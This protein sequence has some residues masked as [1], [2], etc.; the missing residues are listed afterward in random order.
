MHNL[1]AIKY[2]IS[3]P[4]VS[5]TG[6][7]RTML[8]Y[9]ASHF[10][11]K[12]PLVV[13]MLDR[14]PDIVII[15]DEQRQV[16]FANQALLDFVG[17]QQ[18]QVVNGQ[19]PGDLLGCDHA[20][21]GCGSTR[22][23]RTCGASRAILASLKGE[24]S[25]EECRIIRED[26]RSLDLRV[27][28][29]P[30]S[31]EDTRFT[32]FTVRDISHEKRRQILEHAFFHDILNTAGTLKGFADIVSDATPDELDYIMAHVQRTAG[33]LIDEINAQKELVAAEND[34]LKPNMMSVQSWEL[35]EG[36][37]EQYSYHQTAAHRSILMAEKAQDLT[38][39]TDPT[40]LSR[41]LSN[42]IKNALEASQPGQTV[43]LDCW[44]ED[45]QIAFSIHNPMTMSRDV[46]LQLFQRSFSTKGPGRGIGTYSVR[47]LTE[48]YLQ[49]RVT[50]STSE[51]MGTTFIVHYP[52]HTP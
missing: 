35:L 38:F 2:A 16:M 33:R 47:L 13:D 19:R 14:I 10:F 17:T 52:L 30:F 6:G 41:V 4:D 50:F 39:T 37:R 3:R 45:D 49:G 22:F 32:V 25:V 23:C 18:R 42:L 7:I 43:T 21:Q 15:L 40:L 27:W 12:N 48:R 1:D 28:A 9:D 24:Q 36:L 8:L 46:Q 11:Q 29:R 51:M 26:G 20:S 5:E 34:E 44:R 31:I